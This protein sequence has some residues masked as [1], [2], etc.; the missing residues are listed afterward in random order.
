MANPF[1]RNIMP[2]SFSSVV[3]AENDTVT[4]DQA[5]YSLISWVWVWWFRNGYCYIEC[6]P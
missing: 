5:S 4:I 2:R 6:I 1:N 3:I